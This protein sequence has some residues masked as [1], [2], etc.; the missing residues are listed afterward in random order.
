[1][2]ENPHMITIAAA[3]LSCLALP[4]HCSC[5]MPR[6]NSLFARTCA[7]HPDPNGSGSIFSFCRHSVPN[8]ASRVA[9]VSRSACGGVRSCRCSTRAHVRSP[10]R[11]G[12]DD[13]HCANLITSAPV[14]SRVLTQQRH[15]SSSSVG[16]R[17]CQKAS[18]LERRSGQKTHHRYSARA[19]GRGCCPAYVGASAIG[20]GRVGP[21]SA[22]GASSQ[23]ADDLKP[24]LLTVPMPRAS[25]ACRVES[26]GSCLAQAAVPAF[27]SGSQVARIRLAKEC[28]RSDGVIGW[29]MSACPM[30][31][32]RRGCMDAP[33]S[34]RVRR[35][36]SEE[37]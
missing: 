30:S 11:S 20:V 10:K 7:M 2:G 36:R 37:R 24:R 21:S 14:L 3:H 31:A 15:H 25:T 29:Y 16:N 19:N 35:W 23:S 34:R 28:V 18:G 9:S 12:R 5:P 32:Q 1:M 22:G 13:A 8:I 17:V 27:A 4:L 33:P 6:S 26:F